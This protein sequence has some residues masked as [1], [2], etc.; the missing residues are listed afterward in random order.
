[1][2]RHLDSVAYIRIQAAQIQQI[3]AKSDSGDVRHAE[4]N[5]FCRSY[6][7]LVFRQTT[8]P[9]IGIREPTP[10]LFTQDRLTILAYTGEISL[11]WKLISLRT[12]MLHICTL[13]RKNRKIAGICSD[14]RLSV[15][16]LDSDA[17]LTEQH[18]EFFDV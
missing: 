18:S 2:L 4:K 9:I 5:L 3:S 6:K 17:A 16:T 1:M 7:N 8:G 10:F 15:S 14:Q 11:L 13:L 12:E